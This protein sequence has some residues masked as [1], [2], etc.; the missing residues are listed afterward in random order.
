MPDK[1][2][3]ADVEAAYLDRVFAG[4][5][6]LEGVHELQLVAGPLEDDDVALERHVALAKD[7]DG[8]RRVLPRELVGET[9]AANR[10]QELPHGAVHQQLRPVVC[11]YPISECDL[12]RQK[13]L[14]IGGLECCHL[15][16]Q[17]LRQLRIKQT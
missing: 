10:T 4:R 15:F 9:D 13:E 7:V 5:H 2:A 14:L 12:F 8:L 1:S 17:A 3:T 6:V 16:R 11:R